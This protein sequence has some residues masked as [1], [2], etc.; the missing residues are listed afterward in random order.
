MSSN[1]KTTI[2][3]SQLITLQSIKLL[4]HLMDHG[5][6]QS[7]LQNDIFITMTSSNG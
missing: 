3:E 7:A 6:I 4:Q 1:G 2:I 5:W